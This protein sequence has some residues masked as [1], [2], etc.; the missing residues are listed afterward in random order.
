MAMQPKLDTFT[1]QQ[2]FSIATH[3]QQSFAP[4]CH[5]TATPSKIKYKLEA[6]TQSIKQR[7]K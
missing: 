4:V 1:S 6:L 2:N 3:M 7:E 5:E